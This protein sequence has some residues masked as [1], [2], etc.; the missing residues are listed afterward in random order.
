MAS[1]D[2]LVISKLNAKND[3]FVGLID[4]LHVL[5]D[6][7]SNVITDDAIS[8]SS[9]T[10]H[11]SGGT[12]INFD[13]MTGV[14]SASGA[15]INTMRT[16]SFSSQTSINV[17]H[18]ND[19]YPFVQVV[20]TS[21]NYVIP[22]NITHNTLN[23]FTVTFSHAVSGTIL[24]GGSVSTIVEEDAVSTISS[25]YTPSSSDDTIICSGSADLTI[26]LPTAAVGTGKKYVLKNLS[27]YNVVVT[28]DGSETIDGVSSVTILG[29]AVG[30]YGSLE[31]QSDGS[32]WV[33]I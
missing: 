10:Q 1:G 13:Q 2:V 25:N 26:S 19:E 28:P 16:Q 17:V 20:N 24:Y 18:N 23:D 12:G 3:A 32:N 9:V 8:L 21:G 11:L 33:I 15:Q 30:F 27:A 29:G 14:I 31:I 5:G 7:A 22:E 6:A 4:A